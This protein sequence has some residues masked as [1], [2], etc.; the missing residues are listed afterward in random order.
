V[1]INGL[2]RRLL[3]VEQGPDGQPIMVGQIKDTDKGKGKGKAMA[4]ENR[5]KEDAE[6]GIG[7][8][9]SDGE[10]DM[11]EETDTDTDTDDEPQADLDLEIDDEEAAMNGPKKVWMKVQEEENE[12]HRKHEPLVCVLQY[13][14]TVC[15]LHPSFIFSSDIQHQLIGII[16]L[17]TTFIT[18]KLD[19]L[20]PFVLVPSTPES[21]TTPLPALYTRWLFAC[22]ILIDDQ[23][24]SQHMS[25]IRDLAR[26]AMKVAAWRWIQAVTD[27]EVDA[28][29]SA[30]WGY[31]G[32]DERDKGECGL[33]ETLGRCWLLVHAVVAGW[34]QKDLL[35]D[36]ENMFR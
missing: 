20:S 28:S 34:N 21:T 33:E 30:S 15:P 22:L 9:D 35:E 6:W 29:E 8:G 11:D 32:K 14:D 31:K 24:D 7:D 10:V 27:K 4:K 26:C 36:L 19:L 16:E 25:A 1:F 3:H 2:K 12:S 17:I 23:L 13:Y 18:E 5:A